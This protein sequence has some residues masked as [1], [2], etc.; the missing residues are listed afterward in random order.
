MRY[1]V[2]LAILALV[3]MEANA[4]RVVVRGRNNNVA[5]GGGLG[6]AQAVRGVAPVGLARNNVA[7][8]QAHVGGFNRSFV[9]VGFNGFNRGLVGYNNFAFNGIRSYGYNQAAFFPGYGL[10]YG[11][12]ANYGIGY[13]PAYG[14]AASYAYAPA[15]YASY[16]V[17]PV[18]YALPPQQVVMLQH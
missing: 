18:T 16:A 11:A 15:S 9:G 6:A 1:L 3:G 10:N 12:A 13:A 5:V 17:A 8:A 7:L 14:Y 2:A 4:Q